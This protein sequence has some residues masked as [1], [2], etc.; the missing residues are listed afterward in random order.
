MKKMRWNEK[1]DP[2]FRNIG[3]YDKNT[4]ELLEDVVLALQYKKRVNGFA[5][6]WIA[7]NQGALEAFVKAGLQ[8]RDYDV[9]FSVL[10]I[11][12]FNNYIQL[13]QGNIVEKL[14]MKKENVSRSIRKLIEIGA[15]IEG[16]RIGASKTYRLDPEF[17][18]K[19]S[20]KSHVDALK[21]KMTQ[22]GLTIVK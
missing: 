21:D 3:S 19:G 6:G 17:G 1:N 9:L 18:W 7:M 5:E 4:G 8:G 10:Q 14:N 15:L 16:P 22:K 20:A 13:C 11:L 12:D 2:S